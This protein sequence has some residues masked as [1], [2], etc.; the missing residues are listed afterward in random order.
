MAHHRLHHVGILT[1][2]FAPFRRLADTLDFTV[3]GPE[4]TADGSAEVALVEMPGGRLE[5]V[6]PLTEDSA[7]AEIIREGRGGVHHLAFE[8]DD[9]DRGSALL[10]E[11]G[12]ATMVPV[13]DGVRGS[14]M[15]FHLVADAAVE[16]IQWA[17]GDVWSGTSATAVADR[18]FAAI[19]AADVATM[20]ELYRSD[21]VVRNHATGST[22]GLE[23]A[24]AGA[25]KI[26]EQISDF[27]YEEVVCQA[28]DSGFVRRHEVR[29]TSPTGSAFS[30][31]ACCVATVRDG[32]VVELD[33]YVDSSA[34]AT[35]GLT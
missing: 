24:C 27:R 21:V 34:L 1:E 22:A 11:A 25:V 26:A 28:T 8:V 18:L 2:D 17:S 20:R 4:R 31:S 10:D 35:V 30:V 6:R 33:E 16:T 9:V 19:E 14:R 3:R 5:L 23:D 7:V 13:D 32:R 12:F 15:G 29:G